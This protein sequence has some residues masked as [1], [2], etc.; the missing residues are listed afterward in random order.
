MYKEPIAFAVAVIAAVLKVPALLNEADIRRGNAAFRDN[1]IYSTAAWM[2]S[3]NSSLALEQNHTGMPLP[4]WRV[5]ETNFH[6][7]GE[8]E[9]GTH[10]TDAGSFATWPLTKW[11]LAA[12]WPSSDAEGWPSRCVVPVALDDHGWMDDAGLRKLVVLKSFARQYRSLGLRVTLNLT[13]ANDTL[14][15]QPEFRNDLIYLGLKSG[16]ERTLKMSDGDRS[17]ETILTAPDGRQVGGFAGPVQLGLALR[18]AFGQPL[19]S[20]V[21]ANDN[22]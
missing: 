1:T 19:Y 14:F 11:P 22:E 7:L 17:A 10:Q 16:P 15:S 18:K 13:A 20:Q 5:G 9:S 4:T 6:S 21:K 3:S 2:V 8:L 12:H